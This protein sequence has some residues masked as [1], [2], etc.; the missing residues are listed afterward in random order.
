MRI[1]IFHDF[2]DKIGG[3]ERLVLEL[4]KGLDADIITT[5]FESKKIAK[6]GVEG[7]KIIE[8]PLLFRQTPMK[9]LAASLAFSSCDFTKDYDFFMFSGYW[10]VFAANKHKP[11]IYYCHSP[12]RELY[13]LKD[14]YRRR[15][16]LRKRIIHSFADVFFRPVFE[17]QLEKVQ[18]IMTNSL[19]TKEKIKKYYGRDATVVY[20]PI[21]TA[22]YK[23][24]GFGNY[25]LSVNRLYPNKRIEL[26]IEAFRMLP[27]E[28]L[29]V[30][31]GYAEGDDAEKYAKKLLKDKP[32]NVEFALEIDEGK[33]IDLYANCKGFVATAIDED[34]GMSV[35]EAMAA[36]KA[37]VAVDEGGFKETIL[38]GKTGFLV[39]A[40]AKE[41]A[42]AVRIVSGNPEKYKK[43]CI[44]RAGE[45]D[46]RFFI[47]KITGI[48]KNG[49]KGWNQKSIV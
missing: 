17:W 43:E 31:G 33:L 29:V 23:C 3:G 25:W 26:Q 32:E 28:R 40:D 36:G 19:N 7:V 49:T 47:S 27:G 4:A 22:K 20:P 24:T 21:D 48:M 16:G 1:A 46:K 6:L 12:L 10:A 45:F 30:V 14:F 35:V 2:F 15:I 38:D 18:K 34:F 39:K 8:L 11:N 41:I 37:V 13:D 9:Q 5:N 44:G 42:D